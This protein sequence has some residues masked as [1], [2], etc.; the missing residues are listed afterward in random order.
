M[1]AKETREIE[2]FVA[3]IDSKMARSVTVGGGERDRR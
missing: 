2:E 1:R 3:L